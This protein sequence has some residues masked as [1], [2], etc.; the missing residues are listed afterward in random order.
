M[1]LKLSDSESSSEDELLEE[2]REE[3]L[4]RDPRKEREWVKTHLNPGRIVYLIDYIQ[5]DTLPSRYTQKYFMCRLVSFKRGNP[6][7]LRLKLMNPQDGIPSATPPP[8]NTSGDPQYPE[9]PGRLVD[10]TKKS[11]KGLHLYCSFRDLESMVKHLIILDPVRHLIDHNSPSV[12]NLKFAELVFQ[13]VWTN[14]YL[15]PEL[16]PL[17]DKCPQ[18][19]LNHV[20]H[21]D[22]SA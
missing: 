9:V 17:K 1:A 11:H 8:D 16:C 21:Y 19:D 4:Q 2:W 10:Y 22:H 3:F 18:T 12:K 6:V 7:W 20:A 15:R 13:N 5:D 14:L